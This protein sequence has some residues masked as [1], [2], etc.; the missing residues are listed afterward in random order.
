[1]LTNTVSQLH[2]FRPAD[3]IF[4]TRK[5]P[6]ACSFLPRPAL[7][8]VAQCRLSSTTGDTRLVSADAPQRIR[9]TD[10]TKRAPIG[11]VWQDALNFK[12]NR[13]FLYIYFFNTWETV[14]C[15]YLHTRQILPVYGQKQTISFFQVS[16]TGYFYL[17][18][19]DSICSI[20]GREI[21]HSVAFS[22]EYQE[23]YYIEISH[24]WFLANWSLSQAQ[25]S[26]ISYDDLKVL[27]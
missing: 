3:C 26:N 8:T 21:R 14:I 17:C 11:V 10:G 15:F 4:V 7:N 12:A 6:F 2:T 20:L 25:F 19:N 5:T 23:N 27:L 9:V 24:T 1:M 22:Q 13:A 16:A 18:G